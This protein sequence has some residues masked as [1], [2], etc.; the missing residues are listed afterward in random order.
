MD[1]NVEANATQSSDTF[2]DSP[3]RNSGGDVGGNKAKRPDKK[4]Y[5]PKAKREEGVNSE[6]ESTKAS[7]DEVQKK[8]PQQQMNG[9][10]GKHHPSS[11]NAKSHQNANKP[12]ES[13]QPRENRPSNRQQ[14]E[15]SN[16]ERI[17][18]AKPSHKNVKGEMN[19]QQ[20]ERSSKPRS[21]QEREKRS[22][23][24]G[25][26]RQQKDQQQSGNRTFRNTSS[27][28]EKGGSREDR[29]PY[30]GKQ[31]KE[32]G[33]N[34]TDRKT[35][36]RGGPVGS[37]K[38]NRNVSSTGRSQRPRNGGEGFEIHSDRSQQNGRPN[39]RMRGSMELS[40]T[41]QTKAAEA[42][43]SQLP[44]LLA[45]TPRDGY[46]R[47]KNRGNRHDQNDLNISDRSSKNRNHYVDDYDDGHKGRGSRSHNRTDQAVEEGHGHRGGLL[48]VNS[49][50]Q[51]HPEDLG[52][53]QLSPFSRQHQQQTVIEET[54]MP[55]AHHDQTLVEIKMSEEAL[56]RSFEASGLN[57]ELCAMYL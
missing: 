7:T 8:K 5:V 55:I 40:I 4:L 13:R 25:G 14:G 6:S 54:S 38:T 36:G 49:S 26:G 46:G 56:L 30:Q 24:T 15:R 44:D 41:E 23:T 28:T 9:N 10:G 47:N 17:K 48:F 1:T 22:T 51:S 35:S 12:K 2:T 29:Q 57:L 19:P 27:A 11:A 50:Y 52:H 53:Q 45:P 20:S 16:G 31:E 34:A 42:I 18:S 39:R 32:G 21:A 33:G 43:A 3:S 37:A